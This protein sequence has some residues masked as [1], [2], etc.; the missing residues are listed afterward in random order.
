M[1]EC[2]GI[3]RQVLGGHEGG[4]LRMAFDMPGGGIA[5][6]LD[7][8]RVAVATQVQRQGQGMKEAVFTGGGIHPVAM[9]PGAVVIGSGPV[10][11]HVLAGNEHI[12]VHPKA[13]GVFVQSLPVAYRPAGSGALAVDDHQA[14]VRWPVRQ[15][16]HE[17]RDDIHDPRVPGA[18][19]D[20]TG[21]GGHTGWQGRRRIDRR[22]AQQP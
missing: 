13:I 17:G 10:Q 1:F 16:G 4:D 11:H 7:R 3:E 14:A 9:E 12:R 5:Q 6:S 18:Q 21:Y 20:Q 19:A 2:L 22:A 15:A 8:E